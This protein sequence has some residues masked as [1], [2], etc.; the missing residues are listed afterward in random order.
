[1]IIGDNLTTAKAIAIELDMAK[2][3]RTCLSRSDIQNLTR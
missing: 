2:P 1:M 3:G